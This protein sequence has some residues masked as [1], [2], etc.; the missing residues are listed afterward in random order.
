MAAVDGGTVA[1]VGPTTTTSSTFSTVATINDAAFKVDNAKYLIVAIGKISGDDLDNP[2][3]ENRMAQ[4]STPTEIAGSFHKVE[5]QSASGTV[6]GPYCWFTIFTQPATAE[7]VVFQHRSADG[8]SITRIDDLHLFWMRIDE[9][10]ENTD[11][12]VSVDTSG[13]TEHTN[14]TPISRNA[15]TWTPATASHDWLILGVGTTTIDA[16]NVSYVLQLFDS[17]GS[18][19][20]AEHRREGEDVEETQLA[21]LVAV[22]E[23]LP[24]SS[25]TVQWRTNDFNAGTQHD[26]ERSTLFCLDLNL[27]EDHITDVQGTLS[28][29]DNDFLPANDLAVTPT[30]AGNW[31]IIGGVSALANAG[32]VRTKHQIQL[33]ESTIPTGFADDPRYSA[34]HDLTDR[35]STTVAALPN[36]AASLQNIDIDVMWQSGTGQS[37]DYRVGA[38]WSLELA[39]VAVQFL[40]P[41]NDVDAG[42]WAPTPSSPTTLFDKIDEV[43]ASDTDYISE[44]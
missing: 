2:D 26:Y 43:T 6:G 32:G 9:L 13:P 4:G 10:T 30:T 7:D 15:L 3:V 18:A 37:W 35:Q 36:L 8:V 22:L 39:A 34:A 31:F 16:A 12:K 14:A 20:L 21:T 5:P 25:Q 33:A 23:N 1:V 28:Q 41:D 44:T 29:V 27:F 42:G 17:T 38:A 40:R 19:I 24:A 11:W